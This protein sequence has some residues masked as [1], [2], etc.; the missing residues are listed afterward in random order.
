MSLFLILVGL[1]FV[2]NIILWR[3]LMS[4]SSDLTAAATALATAANALSTTA[5][6]VT[7]LVASL[8]SGQVLDQAT[9]DAVVTSL[10]S[11]VTEVQ[12]AQTELQAL[13]PTTPA[14]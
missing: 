5:T 1:I 3:K 13:I 7:T 4:T 2:V 10:Q 6:A 9:L 14:A 11:S 8:K 12:K